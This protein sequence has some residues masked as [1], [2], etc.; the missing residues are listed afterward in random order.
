MYFLFGSCLQI[1]QRYRLFSHFVKTLYFW[2]PFIPLYSSLWVTIESLYDHFD[3]R[4]NIVFPF[5]KHFSNHS[6][7][8]SYN[9]FSTWPSSCFEFLKFT[10]VKGCSIIWAVVRALASH[11]VWFLV[12]ALYVD[13]LVEFLFCSKGFPQGTPVFSSPQKPLFDLIWLGFISI[14][15]VSNYCLC[16]RRSD[17]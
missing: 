14:Y 10:L 9:G 5:W 8:V 1:I 3:F 12:S 16:A 7:C 6:K 4:K 2:L 15:S 13:E 17:S 11:R